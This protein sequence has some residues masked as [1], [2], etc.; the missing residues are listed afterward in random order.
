MVVVGS[1][2]RAGELAVEHQGAEAA[3]GTAVEAAVDPVLQP[4][5]E[6]EDTART[7]SA[8]DRVVAGSSEPELRTDEVEER[9]FT[10][11]HKPSLNAEYM[12]ATQTYN[13]HRKSTCKRGW[14]IYDKL[15]YLSLISGN[16]GPIF[17]RLVT[18]SGDRKP[19]YS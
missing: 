1:D 9:G 5:L 16:S 7:G 14:F 18:T 2:R 12:T 3:P 6:E 8:A 17:L 4:V 15:T 13:N 10:S 11:G 19:I